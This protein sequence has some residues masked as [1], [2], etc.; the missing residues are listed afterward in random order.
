MSKI[1]LSE[2]DMKALEKALNGHQEPPQELAKKMFPS[3]CQRQS[4][5]GVNAAV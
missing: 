3:M 5:N 4:E 2:Q 1:E